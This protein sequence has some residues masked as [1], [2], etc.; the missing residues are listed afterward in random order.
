DI[1]VHYPTLESEAV[2]ASQCIKVT[3]LDCDT[4]GQVKEKILQTFLSKNGYAFSF[5]PCDICLELHYGQTYK[6]LLD[7]DESSVVMEN[8]FKKL[9][10]VNHYKIENGATVKIII[11]KNCDPAKQY[12]SDYVHL[13][14][15]ET[16]ESDDLQNL[17]NKG[18]QKFKVKEMY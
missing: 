2:D 4:I 8:D 9:N 10:T 16:E 5:S 6:E 15:P 13:E 17:E 14:L 11:R 12:T 7:I 18:K 1:N 3:V